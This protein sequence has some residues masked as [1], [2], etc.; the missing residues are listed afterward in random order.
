L[1]RTPLAIRSKT[2]FSPSE[3]KH[4]S[5]SPLDHQ[6]TSSEMSKYGRKTLETSKVS[7]DEPTITVIQAP[8]HQLNPQQYEQFEKI[9]E[10]IK[11]EI[12]LAETNRSTLP[13]LKSP[14]PQSNLM[15]RAA[16]FRG[17]FWLHR[18]KYPARSSDRKLR[19]VLEALISLLNTGAKEVSVTDFLNQLLALGVVTD[20]AAI[21]RVFAYE[22]R[23]EEI[24]GLKLSFDQLYEFCK[25]CMLSN[26][27]LN[28]MLKSIHSTHKPT[29]LEMSSLIH[30]WWLTVD[31]EFTGSALTKAVIDLLY[32]LNLVRDKIELKKLLLKTSC[33]SHVFSSS[34]FRIIFS[35]SM[36]RQALEVIGE[37]IEESKT[38][39]S[40]SPSL[41]LANYRRKLLFSAMNFTETGIPLREGLRAIKAMEK[42]RDLV[43]G[44][45]DFNFSEMIAR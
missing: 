8:N 38:G 3:R 30:T 28:I 19:E 10:G 4:V 26:H 1:T 29:D 34:Q 25:G 7:S 36:L 31:P 27:I 23:I 41:K 5:R 16:Q 43:S 13:R 45:D 17:R 24:S 42:T 35:Q 6:R 9:F 12:A 22:Y 14:G 32:R 21:S 15:A 18:H 11:N 44:I 20:T 37:R 39:M 2:R 33:N 40:I